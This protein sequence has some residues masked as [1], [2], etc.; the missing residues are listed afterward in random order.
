MVAAR[1]Y[2]LALAVGDFVTTHDSDDWSHPQKIEAQVAYLKKHEQ[3]MG[4]VVHW[5]RA[6]PNLQF[7]QNWRPEGSLTHWSHSSFMFRKQVP[8]ELGGWDLV[9]IGADT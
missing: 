8:Q 5:V 7:T 3:V 1:N 6:E 4:C 2:G 9:R